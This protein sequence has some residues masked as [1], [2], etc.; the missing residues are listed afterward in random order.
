MS[1]DFGPVSKTAVVVSIDSVSMRRDEF[2]HHNLICL[3]CFE[4]R[5][6]ESHGPGNVP[7]IYRRS[8]EVVEMSGVRF[9]C[10]S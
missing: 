10:C 3:N 2:P 1:V 6:R 4:S 9:K 5:R 7:L 8:E